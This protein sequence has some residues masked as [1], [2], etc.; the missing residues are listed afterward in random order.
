MRYKEW[1]KIGEVVKSAKMFQNGLYARYAVMEWI[2]MNGDRTYKEVLMC[3]WTESIDVKSQKQSH[4]D[5]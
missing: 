2:E 4:L 1:V 5:V 3:T